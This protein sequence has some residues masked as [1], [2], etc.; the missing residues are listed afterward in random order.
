[1]CSCLVM[2]HCCKCTKSFNEIVRP[3]P[4]SKWT[5]PNRI[6]LELQN[7]ILRDFSTGED[8][9]AVFIIPPQAGHHSNIAD[10]GKGKSLVEAALRAG[11]KSV[12]AA[13]WKSACFARKSETIDDFIISMQR[14]IEAIGQKVALIGLC[15]GG[16]QSAIY[17]A[18][19]PRDVASLTL[20]GAPIDFH[21]GESKIGMYSSLLPMI[22]YESAVAMGNGILD[23]RF[24]LTGFKMLNPAERF[25]GD[26]VDLYLNL[27]DEAYLARY[28]KFRDWYECTQDL[29]GAFFLQVVRDLFKGNKLIE[30]ELR[31]LGQRVD[32][33][34]INHPL[35]LVVGDKDD[36]T[37]E[38]QLFNMERFVSSKEIMKLTVPA[39]HIGVF[40]GSSVVRN[41]WPEIFKAIRSAAFYNSMPVQGIEELAFC[42]TMPYSLSAGEL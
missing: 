5:T 17:T 3:V 18:L 23:G 29:P 33:G 40:M 21:A 39:G 38:R 28:R 27:D 36:I 15:Q 1:M 11:I 8:E 19:F 10:Y 26:Y 12:Y 14:C 31:I 34:N 2:D 25:Y 16:W 42:E 4:R 6:K 37:P 20:A 41:Y 32:L 30:G 22:F 35:F 13:E 9:T 24:L 7:V